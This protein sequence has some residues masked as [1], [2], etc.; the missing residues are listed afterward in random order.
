MKVRGI[1]VFDLDNTLACCNVSFAFGRFLFKKKE[2]GISYALFLAGVYGLHKLGVCS[3]ARL[4]KTAFY[5]FFHK[6][7]AKKIG[8]LADE[9]LSNTGNALFRSGILLALEAAKKE[10]EVVWILSSSPDF[11]VERIALALGV[12]HYAGSC[13]EEDKQGKFS[14]VCS[15]M[16]GKTKEAVLD[17]YLQDKGWGS[18]AVYSD[19][20]LDL[21]L[22]EKAARPIAVFPD[23]ALRRVAKSKSWK[24]WEGQ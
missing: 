22:L 21:P 8:L 19:S 7:N 1:S 14:H 11:L 10:K 3:L 2:L 13:Y 5:L 12:D 15:L 20:I 4:H 23:K 18:V 9:F 16:D 24:I 17:Q 6:K